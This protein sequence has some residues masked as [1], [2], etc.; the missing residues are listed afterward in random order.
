M[1]A[2]ALDSVEKKIWATEKPR[3]AFLGVGWIGA[4][5][6]AALAKSGLI[7]ICAI[8][9]PIPELVGKAA[10]HAPAAIHLSELDELLALELDAIVIATPSAQHAGQSITALE[11]GL[12]VFCQ[13]PLGR[14]VAEVSAVI[15]AARCADR[16][17]G[18]DL[19]YRFTRA[20]QRIHALVC[21]GA[22]GEI[23]AVNLVFHNAYGPDKPWFYDPKQSGGGCLIDLG[24]HLVDA[25][26]WVLDSKVVRAEGRLFSNGQFVRVGGNVC[27]DYASARL[28]LA[29]GAVVD[30]A[31]SWN[32]HAGRDAIIE[33]AFYGTKGGAAMRNVNGSFFDF[34]AECFARTSREILAQPPDDWAGRAA[35]DWARKL[36][37]K[38]GYHPEIERLIDVA[39]VLDSIYERGANV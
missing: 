5:R 34:E 27:E 31:C 37:N 2:P 13:K 32:L 39:A 19:S 20:M 30:L 3:V 4:N 6:L 35:I 23:F 12:A 16:L 17:L 29:S 36:A 24:I 7:E 38:N 14:N 22:L 11:H 26:L 1:T 15:D 10:A 28:D 18:V 9:D 33:M 25:A 21:S 8:A